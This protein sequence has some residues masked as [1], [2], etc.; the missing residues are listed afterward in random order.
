M[1]NPAPILQEPVR[2]IGV[3]RALMLGDM[4]C[5]LPTLRALHAR[6]P[7]A[8]LVLIG[9]PWA[10]E[11]ASRQAL[12]H[13][14]IAFPG[15]PGLPEQAVRTERLPQFLQHMQ[16]E[17]FDLLVQLHGSG[18]VVN[19][20]VGA[21]GARAT[22]GFAE[23]GR[24]CADPTLH[25]PW[26]R[27]GHEILRLL[28][29]TDHLGIA[30]QGLH[31][32]WPIHASDRS[33]LAALVP[34]ARPLACLHPGARFA[35]RRW[36]ARHF[37]A[38]GDRLAGEGF[39]VVLS[40]SAAEAPLAAEVAGHMRHPAI[41]LTGRT[42]L[43]TL[44]ALVEA[45]AVVVTNDTGMSHVAV[46]IGTPSVV[47]SCG[48][49]AARWAPLD[50]RRHPCF[51]HDLPCRPCMHEHCPLP[52]HECAQAVLPQSVAAAALAQAAWTALPS[53]PSPPLP[54][55]LPHDPAAAAFIQP[56]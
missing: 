39:Q 46:A 17:H 5:A 7:Q 56:R 11:W 37:A 1:S 14:F 28:A 52:R 54:Q 26:P 38:V 12:I 16:H 34:P 19:P 22:A 55:A 27:Q 53:S 33:R 41:D 40:G 20:L 49:D 35:S 24:Y 4:L 45:A 30:R 15:W 23:P 44:G 18:D 25:R 47:I 29:L 21:C 43:W 2:R 3:L 10:A 50:A 48:S 6:W 51:W 13:R 32:E 36:P 8:E 42:D 9:L 31:L